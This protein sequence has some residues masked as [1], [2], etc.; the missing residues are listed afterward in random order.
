MTNTRIAAASILTVTLSTT[1]PTL[2]Q[3]RE[4]GTVFP[5]I[6]DR[7]GA[8]HFHTYLY[9]GP[10]RPPLPPDEIVAKVKYTTKQTS[11]K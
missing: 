6:F 11:N 9:Y 4:N 10:I 8:R 7:H 5:M 2:A 3:S 1:S